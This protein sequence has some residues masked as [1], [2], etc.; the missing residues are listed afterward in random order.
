MDTATHVRTLS[1]STLMNEP[2]YNMQREKIGKI[3]DY[4]LDLDRGCVEYAVLSF[5]GFLGI[6]EKLFAIPWQSMTLDTENH[7]WMVDVSE[8]RLDRAP[9]F[10]RDHWPDMGEASYRD[11]ISSFWAV[12]TG[13]DRDAYDTSQS[14]A[15]R[16]AGQ[17]DTTRDRDI[18]F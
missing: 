5:G 3:E 17:G 15:T 16:Y 9:G 18:D 13:A 10:D 2:V 6:G 11:S 8:E 12:N 1:V 7:A 4:M 14:A